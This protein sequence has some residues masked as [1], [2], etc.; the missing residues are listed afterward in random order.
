[1]RIEMEKM[2]MK[3][4]FEAYQQSQQSIKSLEESQQNLAKREEEMK[5]S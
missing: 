5:R 1:M 3:K 4:E 2:K